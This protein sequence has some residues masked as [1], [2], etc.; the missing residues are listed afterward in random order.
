MYVMKVGQCF[1]MEHVAGNFGISKSSVQTMLSRA[2]KK[3]MRHKVTSL[4]CVG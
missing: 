2:E 1:S 3:M 4:F